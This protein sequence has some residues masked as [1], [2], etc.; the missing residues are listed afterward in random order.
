VLQASRILGAI[1]STGLARGGDFVPITL[2][3]WV[4]FSAFPAVLL[5]WSWAVRPVRP[6]AKPLR[7]GGSKY[8]GA[9][10]PFLLSTSAWL[11]AAIA[12]WGLPAPRPEL[13]PN[14]HFFLRLLSRPLYLRVAVASLIRAFFSWTP[15][16]A[17]LVV[18]ADIQHIY[19]MQ[20]F[21]HQ[22]IWQIHISVRYTGPH[23]STVLRGELS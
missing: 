3:F 19:G 20:Q 8:T 23:L 17:R 13:N 7:H 6:A 15:T 4:L 1:E 2:A 11:P 16:W 21:L 22:Q 12:R 18:A 14:I 9:D 10:S 5:C